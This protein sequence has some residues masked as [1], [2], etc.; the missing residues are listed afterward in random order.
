MV[1]LFAWLLLGRPMVLTHASIF[2]DKGT[3]KPVNE[4]RSPYGG[5]FLATS[6]WGWDRVRNIYPEIYEPRRPVR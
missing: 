5:R 4:Y 1:K 3:G 6:R 2:V